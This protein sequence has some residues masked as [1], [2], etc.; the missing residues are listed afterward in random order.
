MT[1]HDNQ[2]FKTLFCFSCQVYLLVQVSCQDHHWFRGYDNVLLEGIDQKSGNWN[3]PH[4]SFAKYLE[5]EASL[6]QQ[7][8][9]R[10]LD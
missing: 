4:L 9:Y 7:I 3:Y 8:W 5:T 2:I 10:C 1:W 6:E